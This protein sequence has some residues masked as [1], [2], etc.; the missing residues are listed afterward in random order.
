MGTRIRASLGAMISSQSQV[1]WLVREAALKLKDSQ[2]GDFRR[3]I[4]TWR[5]IFC[6]GM[7]TGPQILSRA[8]L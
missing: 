2:P 7:L 3:N 6:K 4:F 5:G 1:D 8:Y